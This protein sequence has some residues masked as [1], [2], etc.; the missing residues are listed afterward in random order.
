MEAFLMNKKPT[1]E[2]LEQRVNELADDG[3]RVVIVLSPRKNLN[4]KWSIF[5][6]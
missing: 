5:W 6:S 1:Y 2:A 3:Y 4:K